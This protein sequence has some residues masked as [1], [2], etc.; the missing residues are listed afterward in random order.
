MASCKQTPIL[1]NDSREIVEQL[2]L[3]HNV[4]VTESH[5][6]TLSQYLYN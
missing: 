5:I 2:Q 6:A 3:I 4:G 1:T